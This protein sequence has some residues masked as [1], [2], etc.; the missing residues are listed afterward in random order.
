MILDTYI[1]MLPVPAS[2]AAPESE[3]AAA[4]ESAAL[5][6]P[7]AVIQSAEIAGRAAQA[8]RP[9]AIGA[10]LT[11]AAYLYLA[12]RRSRKQRPRQALVRVAVHP[13][14]KTLAAVVAIG[15]IWRWMRARRLASDLGSA[16]AALLPAA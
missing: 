3:L 15:Y 1:D 8:L 7:E 10:G 13:G 11:T 5:G 12:R 4:V 16:A 2:V 14:I 9:V 6:D